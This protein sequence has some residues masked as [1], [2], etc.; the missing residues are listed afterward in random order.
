MGSLVHLDV[1]RDYL[2]LER[3]ARRY[4]AEDDALVEVLRE[5]MDRLW[6]RL[7]DAERRTLDA[8]A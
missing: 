4:E 3:M 5:V 2:T 6:Y 8:R 7:T 1:Y